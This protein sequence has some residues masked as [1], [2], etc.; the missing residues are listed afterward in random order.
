M[1]WRA[2][3]NF[4]YIKC[5]EESLGHREA[6]SKWNILLRLIISNFKKKRRISLTIKNALSIVNNP[7]HYFL[8]VPLLRLTDKIIKIIMSNFLVYKYIPKKYAWGMLTLKQYIV[9]LKFK[10]IWAFLCAKSSN[11]MH[12]V[13]ERVCVRLCPLMSISQGCQF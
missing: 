11:L 7:L 12:F 9:Y 2:L 10:C 5:L 3:K 1:C 13:M 8:Q 6:L 4:L